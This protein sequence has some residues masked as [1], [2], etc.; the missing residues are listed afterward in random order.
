[1]FRLDL[2]MDW[3]NVS[4]QRCFSISISNQGQFSYHH[5]PTL[6]TMVRPRPGHTYP[7]PL[8]DVPFSLYRWEVSCGYCKAGPFTRPHPLQERVSGD[9][10]PFDCNHYTAGKGLSWMECKYLTSDDW[11]YS[12]HFFRMFGL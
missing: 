1:M 12:S 3:F 10:R 8:L 7:S 5:I 11:V 9:H 6:E 4:V 2:T